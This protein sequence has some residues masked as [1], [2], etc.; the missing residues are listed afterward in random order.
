MHYGVDNQ[1]GYRFITDIYGKWHM[2][3]IASGICHSISECLAGATA[4]YVADE[5]QQNAGACIVGVAVA[6]KGTVVCT[7]SGE[8]SRR[9]IVASASLVDMANLTYRCANCGGGKF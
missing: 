4:V 2:V 3:T 5:M 8:L 9:C 1:Y 7:G 6:L